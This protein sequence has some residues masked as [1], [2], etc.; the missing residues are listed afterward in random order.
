MQH[1]GRQAD[2][3]FIFYIGILLVFGLL[4]LTSSSSVVGLQKFNDSYFFIKRQI[5]FGLIPGIVAFYIFAKLDYH[6]LK[7]FYFPVFVIACVLL[8]LV[9]IP[10]VGSSLNT[11]SQSW[12]VLGGY[13]FQP[14]EFAKLAL[15]IFMAG[16]L[17]IIGKKLENFQHGF[18]LSLGIGSIPL[19]LV[20][21][22]PDAG[23]LSILFAILF[24][25]LFFAGAR[26]SHIGALAGTGIVLFAIMII[27]APYRAERLMTFLHPELDPQGQ[28]YH[29]NQSFL[30][31]GSGG[32]FGLGLGHSRQK[33]QYLPEVH[34]DSIF[35]IF[36]EE[37]G[38]IFSVALVMLILLIALRGFMIAKYAPDSF[39][40]LLV[41]GIISWFV[42][43]SLLNIGAMIGLLPLT[44]VPLPFVSHGGTALMISLAG[45]GVI[46]NVSKHSYK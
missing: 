1:R 2:Y 19:L 22:Q 27:I 26:Y 10:G 13:S 9:F 16:Y 40:R 25:M 23:T 43:Q 36:A 38:F 6:L 18:L 12:L 3:M 17:S 8:L 7:K 4:I 30:A 39:G 41:A 33:F 46:T 28:G 44:G 45:V 31:V 32:I 11:G 42:A 29:I 21:A 14:A 15:V 20:A 34:A 24:L 5:L 35:A 37:M